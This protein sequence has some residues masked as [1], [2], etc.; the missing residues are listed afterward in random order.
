MIMYE[1]FIY[2]D[3]FMLVWQLVGYCDS[4]LLTIAIVI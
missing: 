2:C 1:V 3:M 4:N